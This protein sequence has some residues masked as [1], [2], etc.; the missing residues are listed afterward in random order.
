MYSILFE[1]LYNDARVLNTVIIVELMPTLYIQYQNMLVNSEGY[2]VIPIYVQSLCTTV[3][4]FHQ[5]N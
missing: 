4:H 3:S 5:C 1:I 2:D